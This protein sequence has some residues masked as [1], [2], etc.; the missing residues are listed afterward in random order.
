MDYGSDMEQ[1]RSLREYVHIFWSRK[2]WVISTFLATVLITALYCF[3]TTPI[4][5]ASSTLQITQDNPGSQ[6]SVDD[7]LSQLTGGSD[8]LEKFQQTQYKILQSRS[9]ALRVIQ[10]LNLA[11]HPDF[12]IIREKHPDWADNEIE[13]AMVERFQKKLEV[14]PVRSTF[15]VELAFQSPDK[16][17]AQKVVNTVASEYMYLSID[18]RNESFTLVRGWLDRQLQEMATKVQAAQK[19]LFKFGQQADIYS[20]EDKDNVIVQKFIDLSGLLTKAQAEKMAKEAQYRQIKAK[21]PNAPLVVNHPLVAALRQQ[22][23]GQQAK[24]SSMKKVFLPGHPEMQAEQSNLK[25]LQGRLTAEVQRLEESIRADY[26]AANRTQKLLNDSLTAQKDQVAKLQDNLTDFQILKRD[27]QTNE[28]LYQ[29]LL[30]RVKEANIAST[31]VPSNVAVIDPGPLPSRK[32]KPKT[33]QNLALAGFLGLTLGIGL[34]LLVEHLDDSI[35]SVDDLEQVCHLP[36]VGVVPLLSENGGYGSS[37]GQRILS[38]PY[39][40]FLPWQKRWLRDQPNL[41]PV[42]NLDLVVFQNPKDPITEALRHTQTSIMLSASGRPPCILMITSANPSEGKSTIASNLAQ[43]FAVYDRKTAI[44][45]CD[46]RKPRVHKIFSLPAQPGLTNYLSG[47][48]SLEEILLTTVIPNLTL[49]AAGAR[50]PNP[51]NLLQSEIFKDLLQELRGK[52]HHIIIDTPPILGFTDA[53][54]VSSLVDGVILVVKQN[55]THKVAGNLA[56]QL[57]SQ[58]HA[59][60]LGAVLNGV[61]PHG[62][63]G[64]YYNIKYYS[65]YY[66]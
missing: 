46:L 31:M 7:K 41:S 58:I 1:G 43:S 59:P 33:T 10:A 5:R 21:G 55:S 4:F 18:R 3:I 29:A 44:I 34:A 48:A 25:E 2:W 15:L 23:V 54:M 66:G 37:L 30:A 64:Y 62:A 27:A 36:S 53:R 51:L 52:F 16:A 13:D 50:P 38:S 47:N 17:M 8:S 42:E 28:Q 20:M 56:R 61:G 63:G 60:I 39:L 11:E 49:I 35:K 45:D 57:L 65:K 26:E 6:V 12:S 19:K 14:T 32:F 9:L 40:S 22:V 24:V